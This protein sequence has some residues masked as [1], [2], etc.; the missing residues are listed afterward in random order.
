[1]SIKKGELIMA[2]KKHVLFNPA[3][4][5]GDEYDPKSRQAMQENIALFEHKGLKSIREIEKGYVW[6]DDWM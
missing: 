5:T 2:K 3:T 4:F 1:M 6:Q